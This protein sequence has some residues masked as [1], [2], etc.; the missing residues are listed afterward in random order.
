MCLPSLLLTRLL[1]RVLRML[2][3]H[4]PPPRRL[5]SPSKPRPS[6][7]SPGP[8]SPGLRSNSR[9]SPPRPLPRPHS[10]NPRQWGMTPQTRYPSARRRRLPL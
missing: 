6:L 10:S 5:Q 2:R 8:H 1:R 9:P 7:R 4:R 3:A